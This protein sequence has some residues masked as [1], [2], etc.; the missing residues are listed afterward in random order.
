MRQPLRRPGRRVSP[1]RKMM[2]IDLEK[3]PE[4]IDI[5]AVAEN[6][7][8]TDAAFAADVAKAYGCAAVIVNPCYLA[9]IIHR[10]ADR[11][12]L[13]CGATSSF[14]FGC[15]LT[16]VKLYGAQQVQLLG[17][18][19]IDIVMNVGEFL[20][21]NTGLV[22]RELRLLV[23]AVE[24]DIKVI[25][26]TALLSDEQIVEA[27]RLAADCGAAYVKSSTGFYDK[28]VTPAQIR[29]MKEAVGDKAKIKASGGIR[30]VAQCREFLEAG[31]SRLGISARSALS[32]LRELDGML[33]RPGPDVG[34]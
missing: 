18:Q 8:E 12:E 16:A 30:T 22:E 25:I 20:S 21:G 34:E 11:K 26:E 6:T 2:N 4:Y 17:A 28:A 14:P 10:R 24:A 9:Q 31:A 13:R 27:S 15:D 29:L 7:T 3:L 19:E 1:C 33:G 32:I 5:A 23:D